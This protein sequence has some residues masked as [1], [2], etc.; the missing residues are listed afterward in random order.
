MGVPVITLAG[1]T[2]ASRVG[3]SLLNAAG[4]PKLV[5]HDED[6]YVRIA[7]ALAADMPRLSTLRATLR[8]TLREKVKAAPLMD[9]ARLARNVE[10]AYRGVWRAW[11]AAQTSAAD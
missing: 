10:A 4:L 2:H 11:C 7:A 5:A 1:K 9:A 8:A 6:D 3:V